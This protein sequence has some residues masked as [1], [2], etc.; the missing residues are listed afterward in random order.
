MIDS[1]LHDAEI[2]SIKHL[3]T[4]GT[5]T[6]ELRTES[7]EFLAVRCTG[8]KGFALDPFEEQNIIFSLRSYSASSLPTHLREDLLPYYQDALSAGG[9]YLQLDPSAG[10]G[11]WIVTEEVRI[12]A[13]A[14]DPQLGTIV[15]P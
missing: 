11:G 12:E 5:L 15:E 7:G 10:M 3:R 13:L 8:V 1:D 4:Q 2:F 6:L 9:R 14:T